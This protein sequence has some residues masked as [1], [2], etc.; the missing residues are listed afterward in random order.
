MVGSGS[1][2]D[3]I[4]LRRSLTTTQSK[5]TDDSDDALDCLILATCYFYSSFD[6][7]QSGARNN[8]SF[9]QTIIMV[10]GA[11]TPGVNSPTWMTLRF[12]S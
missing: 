11:L 5:G 7:N 3:T 12:A 4:E 1:N 6:G 8:W 9:N 2:T 10:V